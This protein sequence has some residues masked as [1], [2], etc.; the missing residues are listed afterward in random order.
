MVR[1]GILN[2]V[3]LFL[4][5]VWLAI[6]LYVVTLATRFVAA[7][8]RIAHALERRLLDRPQT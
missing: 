4:F 2:M 3:P 7:V 6:I 8:E 1:F 5:L